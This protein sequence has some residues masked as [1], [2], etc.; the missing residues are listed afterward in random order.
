MTCNSLG[1]INLGLMSLFYLGGDKLHG[2][3][4]ACWNAVDALKWIK[5]HSE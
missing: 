5:P 3:L 2:T 1:I 4:L